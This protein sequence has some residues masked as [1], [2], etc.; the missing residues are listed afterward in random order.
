[1][2]HIGEKMALHLSA[3]NGSNG[4]SEKSPTQDTNNEITPPK[5]PP[6]TN[7]IDNESIQDLL[8]NQQANFRKLY[9]KFMN[10]AKSGDAVYIF[11]KKWF[12]TYFNTDTITKDDDSTSNEEC[13]KAFFEAP[14]LPEDVNQ[15]TYLEYLKSDLLIPMGYDLMAEIFNFY[16]FNGTWIEGFIIKNEDGISIDENLLTM[17]VCI[18]VES[19]WKTAQTTPVIFTS[20]RYSNL[21]QLFQTAANKLQD[22]LSLDTFDKRCWYSSADISTED[23]YVKDFLILPNDFLKLSN[24]QYVDNTMADLLFPEET[25][26]KLNTL[27]IEI[28]F[29][30]VWPSLFHL[31]NSTKK[32]TVSEQ[33]TNAIKQGIVGLNNLGNTCFMNSA[34]QCLVHVPELV[35]YFENGCHLEELNVDNP[36]GYNGKIATVFGDLIKELYEKNVEKNSIAPRNFKMNLGMCNPMFAGY[37]Q[38][39]SQEF[40]SFLLDGLHEDLNRIKDKP[41]VEN[42]SSGL[43]FDY[44]NKEKIVALAKESWEKYKL[45]NDSVILDLFVGLFES[46]L[47]CPDCKHVSITFDPFNDLSLPIP[48]ET[49]WKKSIY[50][51]PLD[52]D[53]HTLELEMKEDL[54]YVDLKKEVAKY[55]QRD[56]NH[57]IGFEFYSSSIYKCFE[58]ESS[59][60]VF[61]PIGDLISTYD[62]T[63]FVEVGPYDLEKDVIIPIYNS[64]ESSEGPKRFN[65]MVSENLCGY[66]TLI[67]FEKSKMGDFKYIIETI[68]K[69]VKNSTTIEPISISEEH[70]EILK[71]KFDTIVN[72]MKETKNINDK[73]YEDILSYKDAWVSSKMMS[74]WF[75]IG[76]LANRSPVVAPNDMDSGESQVD[77]IKIP[78]GRLNITNAIDLVDIAGDL[79]SELFNADITES[80]EMSLEDEPSAEINAENDSDDISLRSAEVSVDLQ[81]GQSNLQEAVWNPKESLLHA[82]T[83]NAGILILNWKMDQAKQE[84]FY[85]TPKTYLNKALDEKNQLAQEGKSKKQTITLDDCLKRF[86][87]TETLSQENTW[88]CASCKDHKQ[89]DKKIQLWDLPDILCVHLKR[90]KNQSLLS[91]KID[92]LVKFPINDFDL[93]PHIACPTNNEKYVYD[94]IA[95]DNHYGG[96]GGGHYTAYA[97]NAS[98]GKWYYYNDSRVTEADV[99]DSINEAAYLLFYKKRGSDSDSKHSK[100]KELVDKRRAENDKFEKFLDE[101]Q[102]K[103]AI[104]LEKHGVSIVDESDEETDTDSSEANLNKEP[105]NDV[106][107]KY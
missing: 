86:T 66:P 40:L 87:E 20:S 71:T 55:M 61:L 38:Q 44:S 30:D 45:R 25:F 77:K 84:S 32:I 54:K 35:E 98:D 51:L 1:M 96:I 21:G 24:I 41:Y 16:G 46:T 34:L 4:S 26:L 94:L 14:Y 63:F 39:D 17:Q 23:D 76:F 88:Y 47:I 12:A 97:K 50:I 85:K 19:R 18:L 67:K 69:A 93:T 104:L 62:I 36:L 42:S 103:V 80:E 95:V 82:L 92:E 100:L 90:F 106:S 52:D 91:D 56:P 57:L 74:N 10:E 27:I 65:Q 8:K 29:G 89:A 53:P 7:A 68:C 70:E 64:S 75:N 83:Q 79:F 3:S 99:E 72:K 59:G 13:L 102:K 15:I 22:Q 11:P 81:T 107:E 58:N 28:K 31:Y 101:R 60:S 73:I 9:E 43:D 37:S 78:N 48:V 105:E 2:I 5:L 49:F 6:R 33:E